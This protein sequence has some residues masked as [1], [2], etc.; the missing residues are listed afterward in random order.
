MDTD[1]ASKKERLLFPNTPIFWREASYFR[2]DCQIITRKQAIKVHELKNISKRTDTKENSTLNSLSFAE[3]VFDEAVSYYENRVNPV[4]YSNCVE[5]T[6]DSGER[7]SSEALDRKRVSFSR[8]F[9]ELTEKYF[10]KEGNSVPNQTQKSSPFESN[11]KIDQPNHRRKKPELPWKQRNRTFR[12]KTGIIFSR[13]RSEFLRKRLCFENTNNLDSSRKNS[14]RDSHAGHSS[15]SSNKN[16]ESD[17]S[18]SEMSLNVKNEI[19]TARKPPIK[20]IL[21]ILEI[22]YPENNKVQN[23]N[24]NV[25]TTAL[26]SD[27]DG[28]DLLCIQVSSGEQ[29]CKKFQLSQKELLRLKRDFPRLALLIPEP[30]R[31][32]KVE[33]RAEIVLEFLR[34]MCGISNSWTKLIP[35]W[36]TAVEMLALAKTY[37]LKHLRNSIVAYFNDNFIQEENAEEVFKLSHHL[38]VSEV[39]TLVKEFL[40]E[41]GYSFTELENDAVELKKIRKTCVVSTF[42]HEEPLV[43]TFPLH[44]MQDS[45]ASVFPKDVENKIKFES[46]DGHY[47]ISGIQLKFLPTDKDIELDIFCDLSNESEGAKWEEHCEKKLDSAVVIEFRKKLSVKPR[48]TAVINVTIED[49]QPRFTYSGKETQIEEISE[50]GTFVVTPSSNWKVHADYK[51]FF[52]EKIL[53]FAKK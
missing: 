14:E 26:Q 16:F 46:F 52:V 20:A 27:S 37:H 23:S 53:Y 41:L 17:D 1:F 18:K 29:F 30:S 40:G 12:R 8:D 2:E 34:Y 50:Y 13:N 22:G 51:I 49:L 28:T 10:G 36:R 9:V 47:E 21:D 44:K 24:E 15:E 42:F 35:D 33:Y 5:K 31:S 39:L 45:I 43:F 7:I 6:N 25:Q 48:Q 19:P 38:Q 4:K 11:K 32:T 3:K